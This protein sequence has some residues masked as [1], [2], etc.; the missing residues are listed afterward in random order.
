MLNELVYDLC[1]CAP[2]APLEEVASPSVGKV[3]GKMSMGKCEFQM[4]WTILDLA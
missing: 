4:K 1:L 3:S 2:T